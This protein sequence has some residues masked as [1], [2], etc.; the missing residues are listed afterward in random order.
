MELRHTKVDVMSEVV[1]KGGR[2][3]SSSG[4]RSRVPSAVVE[5]ERLHHSNSSF[6]SIRSAQFQEIELSEPVEEHGMETIKTEP[7]S[8]KKIED[9]G[10]CAAYDN[11]ALEL[12]EDDDQE[13]VE[14]AKISVSSALSTGL[15]MEGSRSQRKQLGEHIVNDEYTTD[16][17]T[18]AKKYAIKH[19]AEPTSIRVKEAN[20]VLRNELDDIVP[21]DDVNLKR[22]PTIDSSSVPST[23]YTYDS[24]HQPSTS[25]DNSFIRDETLLIDDKVGSSNVSQA[26]NNNAVPT[27]KEFETPAGMT[28][29]SMQTYK[30]IQ[31]DGVK[32]GRCILTTM[33]V[34]TFCIT[35]VLAVLLLIL[36]ETTK[37]KPGRNDISSIDTSPT[38]PTAPSMKKFL[39]RNPATLHILVPHLASKELRKSLHLNYTVR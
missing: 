9:K 26:G 36:P 33:I 20:S 39:R 14:T 28:E 25:Y 19:S 6:K 29:K 5:P 30:V 10:N 37:S 35:M 18:E 17:P 7:A 2:C 16:V 31:R 8:E 27:P 1:Q 22:S 38:M 21:A 4:S 3:Q 23:S 32:S 13:R 12:N 15:V 34:L 24:L 11:E